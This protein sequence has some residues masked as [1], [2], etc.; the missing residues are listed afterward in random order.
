MSSPC[1]AAGVVVARL[2]GPGA[3]DVS[4]EKA[5]LGGSEELARALAGA[6][7]EL[8]EQV[9]VGSAQEVGLHVGEAQAVAGVGEG[10]DDG[11]ES[12]GV[13][14]ALAVALGRK[15]HEVYD[16][17]ERGVVAHDGAHGPSQVLPDVT[18]ASAAALSVERPV[19]SLSTIDHAPAGLGRQVEAQQVMVALSDLLRDR[20]GP[21]TPGPAAR[22]RRRIRPK[23]A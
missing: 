14:V 15:V 11:G 22:S 16:A 13:E 6:L 5:D 3:H 20:T 17:G 10:L 1:R 19:V 18:R 21:R 7:G 2:A 9:L 23:G 4:H 12:G 8:S